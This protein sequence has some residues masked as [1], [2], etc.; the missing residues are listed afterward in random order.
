MSCQEETRR[1]TF[2]KVTPITQV[3]SV[4]LVKTL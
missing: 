2:S 3:M 4:D 1:Y